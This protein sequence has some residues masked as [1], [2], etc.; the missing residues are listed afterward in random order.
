MYD[1]LKTTA[2]VVSVGAAAFM[3]SGA[4]AGQGI[5]SID[6][7]AQVGAPQG[8]NALDLYPTIADDLTR[9]ILSRVDTTN[10]PEGGVISVKIKRL[11]L[12]GDTILPDSAEFN[13]LEGFLSY[14]GGSRDFVE[15]IR[16]SARTDEQAVPE[17]FVSVAPSNADFYDAMLAAFADRIVE[18]V[19]EED[20]TSGS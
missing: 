10:D 19:P 11:S 20:I 15:M 4:T 9:E 18:L 3:A 7:K 16:L 13:E 5:S 2:L 8:S 1:F 6:V 17:G 14:E 12:D